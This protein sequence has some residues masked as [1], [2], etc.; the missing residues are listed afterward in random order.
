MARRNEWSTIFLSRDL[1][2]VDE[3]QPA[4]HPELAR[5][6]ATNEDLVVPFA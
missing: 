4:S 5:P 1:F 6:S 3:G 2:H